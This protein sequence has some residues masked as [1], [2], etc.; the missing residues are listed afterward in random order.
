MTPRPQ[1][2]HRR[3]RGLL[4]Q[5]RR[6]RSLRAI[7]EWLALSLADVGREVARLTRRESYY[8]RSPVLVW[9]KK[10]GC[11]PDA[12]RAYGTLIAN[13]VASLLGTDDLGV[14]IEANSPLHVRVMRCCIECREWFELRRV[15][16]RRCTSCVERRRSCNGR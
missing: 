14:E 8:D 3:A 4:A 16:Q 1:N 12:L 13:Q 9:E 15:G 11:S 5:V 2:S 10:G 6:L 7:R